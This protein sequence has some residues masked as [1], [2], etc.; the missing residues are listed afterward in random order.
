MFLSTGWLIVERMLCSFVVRCTVASVAFSPTGLTFKIAQ[1]CMNGKQYPLPSGPN[2]TYFIF[3]GCRAQ[4]DPLCNYDLLK[5]IS[6]YQWIC[7][8]VSG[9]KLRAVAIALYY[10]LN[11]PPMGGWSVS[12]YPCPWILKHYRL[13]KNHNHHCICKCDRRHLWKLLCSYFLFLFFCS[14]EMSGFWE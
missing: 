8:L 7:G 4:S 1:L 3:K 5:M 10:S 12:K 2:V 14:S 11:K 9:S 13:I 6:N